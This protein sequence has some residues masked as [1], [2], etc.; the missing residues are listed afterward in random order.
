M[1]SWSDHLRV[2]HFFLF[3]SI[4]HIYQNSRPP[5]ICPPH[6]CSK[7]QCHEPSQHPSCQKSPGIEKLPVKT[8]H[9]GLAQGRHVPLAPKSYQLQNVEEEDLKFTISIGKS[10]RSLE[11]SIAMAI[12]DSPSNLGGEVRQIRDCRSNIGTLVCGRS[13][14][15]CQ[16]LGSL[17]HK[18]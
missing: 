17:C 11:V 12:F 18:K 14:H 10:P 3:F 9:T 15:T 16:D 6:S 7:D 8:G 2:T 4:K 1:A 5:S 13:G